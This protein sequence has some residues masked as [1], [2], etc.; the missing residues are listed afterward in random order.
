MALKKDKEKVLGEVFDDDRIRGFLDGQA[1]QGLNL[2]FYLLERAYRGMQVENFVTFVEFFV[3]AGHDLNATNT[4]GRT[5]MGLVREHS[6]F[7]EY[8]DIL[9]KA[10]AN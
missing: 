2:D 1:P 3:E 10:G 8:L 5:L 9:E 6:A 4:D 7:A